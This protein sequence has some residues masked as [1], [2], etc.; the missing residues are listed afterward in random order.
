MSTLEKATPVSAD[1]LETVPLRRPW[2]LVSGA[3]VAIL[4]AKFV[5]ILITNER[6]QWDVVR[7]Y[8]TF[9]QIIT[10]LSRTLVLTGGA[11]AIGILGGILLAVMRLSDNPLI[12]KA[13]W[14]Y[15]WFFRG[16]PVL[17]QL[18]FWYNLSALFPSLSLGIP[19]GP[20]FIEFNA[21][22]LITVYVAALLGLGLNEAAYMSEIVRSGINS[23]D[24]GQG[25]AAQALGMTRF[26]TFRRVVMPQAMRVIVPPTGN[27]VI[28]MLKTTALVSV[29]ALPDLLYSAQLIYNRNFNPIPLLIVASI[30]YLALT[31]ILSI[32]QFY[33]ERHYNR[34]SRSTGRAGKGAQ[35]SIAAR[36]VGDAQEEGK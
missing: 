18:I 35:F 14:V 31:T 23:V 2:R 12:S 36:R 7:D 19:F 21:N 33:I 4:V 28:G 34:G 15:V 11:M 9:D 13:A 22:D 25:E 32:F 24:P 8:L 17:V 3:V 29:I 27:Q 1:T 10:G 5:H 16:T 20:Q 26:Q 6:F 30:W